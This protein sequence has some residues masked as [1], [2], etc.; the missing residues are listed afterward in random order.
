M[1]VVCIVAV[2]A[3]SG[4]FERHIVNYNSYRTVLYTCLYYPFAAKHLF[5]FFGACAC[6]DVPVKRDFAE[7][8]ITNRTADSIGFK[9]AVFQ[10][11]YRLIHLFGELYHNN[12]SK[13]AFDF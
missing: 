5:G 12:S 10:Q 13:Y 2:Y 8:T 11:A 7:Q 6:C 9:T 1:T 3:I 4:Y